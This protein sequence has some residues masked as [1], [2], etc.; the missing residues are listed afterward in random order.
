MSEQPQT[1]DVVV[2]GG[3]AIGLSIAWRAAQAGLRPLVLD[4]GRVGGGTSHYA[5][6]MLAPVAEV[7]PGEEPLLELGLRSARLYPGFVAELVEAASVTGV[8]Y[9]TSGTLLV[10]R[11]ADEAE[12]LERELALRRRFDLPVER[13][14]ASEAR[15]REPALAPALRL[16]LDVPGDHAVDPRMLVPALAAATARAGGEVR[17][18][19]AVA[20][21]TLTA[22][23]VKG[24][25]LQDGSTVRAEQVVVAAGVWSPQLSGLPE[26]DRVPVRPVKGQIM[27]LHDPAG[28]GLLQRVIRM[29]PTYITPRGDG[30][31]VLG[32][33]SEERGFD[34]TVTAGAGFELL[35]DAA[36]LVPGI[37]ELVIDEFAAG[38]RPGTPDN[39][40]AIGP[41]SVQGLHWATGHRRGGIL[42]APVT[43]ELVVGALTG[44]PLPEYADACAPGRFAAVVASS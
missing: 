31:Y 16:A 41:G 42:L 17:E 14:R 4:R 35:R 39:L 9:T 38:L 10:A 19:S 34:T 2:I 13:L 3:G 6:G 7:T 36:E 29:G 25:V 1:A 11:D 20:G 32:A 30:R 28:P 23:R 5:A 37:S 8:G 24:V 21:V 15:R 44:E 27:R 43:A 26:A 33:T 22:G 18:D 12:A 40:P